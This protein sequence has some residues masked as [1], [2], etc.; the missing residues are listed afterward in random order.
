MIC[1]HNEWEPKLRPHHTNTNRD[2]DDQ[3]DDEIFYTDFLN[4]FF[5]HF[6]FFVVKTENKHS[7][8]FFKWCEQVM[9]KL[10]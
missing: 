1:T 10:I 7:F 9:V 4:I 5:I 8:E 3:K 6:E 2:L